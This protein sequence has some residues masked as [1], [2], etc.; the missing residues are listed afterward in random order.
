MRWSANDGGIVVT[1]REG[2]I[3][4]GKAGGVVAFAHRVEQRWIRVASGDG[5]AAC[6]LKTTQVTLA[7]AAA[8]DDQNGMHVVI[9]MKR[10]QW[11]RD[12]S[13]PMVSLRDQERSVI[14]NVEVL[15]LWFSLSN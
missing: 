7:D 8:A 10:G 5:A 4:R 2:L 1:C 12:E 15:V 14:M 9:T 13:F 3:K 6:F 11:E